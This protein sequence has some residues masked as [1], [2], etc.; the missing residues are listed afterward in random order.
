[1]TSEKNS[2]SADINA[3]AAEALDLWQEQLAVYAADP[4]A[5]AE[6]IRVMEPARHWF[7][8]W[9]TM[10]QHGG[11]GADFFAHGGTP[12]GAG[13]RTGA[14]RAAP[15]RPA[16]DDGA[17]DL[18]QLSHHVAVLEK[19]VAELEK[20]L[21]RCESKGESGAAKKRPKS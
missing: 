20:R 6:L 9:A 2:T 3:L 21:A 16:S 17:L 1:M 12:A 4:K 14:S 19:H 18:A 13:S 8:E 11:H 15:L 5:K 7:A 10:M